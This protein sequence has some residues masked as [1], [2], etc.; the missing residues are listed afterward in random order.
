MAALIRLYH[1][2]GFDGPIRLD[3]AP[4]MHGEHEPWMPGYGVLGRLLAAAYLR[5]I[6]AD[7]DVPLD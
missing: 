5:G 1:M 7:A 6:A 2:M 4:L 3:H